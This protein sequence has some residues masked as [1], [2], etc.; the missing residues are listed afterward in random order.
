MRFLRGPFRPENF[1]QVQIIFPCGQTVFYYLWQVYGVLIQ[2]TAIDNANNLNTVCHPDSAMKKLG[3]EVV[4]HLSSKVSFITPIVQKSGWL[5]VMAQANV[6]NI[7][8]SE[9][10][11][12]ADDIGK[13]FP[14]G[15]WI[16]LPSG[17]SD[18]EVMGGIFAALILLVL[19]GC[20]KAWLDK[21]CSKPA[22]VIPEAEPLLGP[23]LGAA[24]MN[25][26]APIAVPVVRGLKEA[27]E[28]H[29]PEPACEMTRKKER[30]QADRL[31]EEEQTA[32]P[33]LRV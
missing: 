26:Q 14:P 25:E 21:K 20:F 12:L 24:A 13:A 6:T 8:E 9:L 17:R 5:K 33:T 22:V 31:P 3:M 16:P 27:R 18:L 19:C 10:H 28:E 29:L 1:E 4:D 7:P 30:A 11:Q 23:V 15:S 2:F 32:R